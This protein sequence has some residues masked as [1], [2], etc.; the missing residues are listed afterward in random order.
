MFM[1]EERVNFLIED[2][3]FVYPQDKAPP[4]LSILQNRMNHVI[5][6]KRF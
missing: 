1:C 2:L 6:F 4:M 3:G 5:L